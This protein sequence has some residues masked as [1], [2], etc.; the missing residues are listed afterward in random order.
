MLTY[1]TGSF[2][3]NSSGE[4]KVDFLYD[5]GSFQG[6]LGLFNLEGMDA[7]EIGSSEYILEAVRRAESD[8]P[9]G[10]SLID[11]RTEG[12]RFNADLGYEK[13]FN[14]LLF[15]FRSTILQTVSVDT[16]SPQRVPPTVSILSHL[17]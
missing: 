16:P 11:D 1:E 8:S 12:A 14:L 5:G 15:L 7:L 13:N 17:H 9:Q 3:V 4:V 2:I 10:Y 6:E